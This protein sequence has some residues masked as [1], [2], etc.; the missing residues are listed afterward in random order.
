LR[1]ARFQLAEK[2]LRRAEELDPENPRWKRAMERLERAKSGGGVTIE[3]FSAAE[4]GTKRITVGGNV[5]AF[6]LVKS[7]E[8]VYPPLARQA[9]I[10]GAV[11]FTV[12]IDKAGG[13]AKMVLISGHPLLVLAALKALQQYE[14]QPTILGGEPV[15]VV[16]Q[17]DIHFTLSPPAEFR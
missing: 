6:K 7:V 10:Q 3:A 16:T 12:L 15:E 13:I 17:V 14:Y 2:L 9:R 11:R 4:P 5:Q 1:A 8:P